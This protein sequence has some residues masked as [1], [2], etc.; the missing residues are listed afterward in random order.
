M[1]Q[2]SSSSENVE[3]RLR[4]RSEDTSFAEDED[5]LTLCEQLFLLCLNDKTGHI[6]LLNETISFVLRGCLLIELGLRNKIRLE[7]SRRA[8]SERII[9]VIDPQSTG[10]ALL[11]ETI[12]ILRQE[13]HSLSSWLEYLSGETWSMMR[14]H[15]QIKQLK[16]RLAKSLVEKGLLRHS[17]TSYVLFEMAT[18]PIRDTRPK[19][20][21]IRQMIAFLM[22][23]TQQKEIDWS[24][25]AL[26]CLCYAA[27]SLETCLQ[28]RIRG[29]E[30][31]NLMKRT[32]ER[33]H[34]TSALDPR[35]PSEEIIVAV[36][37]VVRK[38]DTIVY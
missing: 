5:R 12:K 15:L 11:D 10:D 27:Q 34:N 9:L 29:M 14:G 25:H 32:Q 13:R 33:L 19:N 21:L 26:T 38:L 18:C 23:Q 7:S 20:E 24:M 16:E 36:L 37:E 17:K 22:E 8:L 28:T 2:F 3:I 31:R 6:S 4:E 30:L 35:T 1:F